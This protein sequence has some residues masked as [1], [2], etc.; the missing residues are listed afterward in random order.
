M[1]ARRSTTLT[2]D[3]FLAAAVSFV[4]E[5]GMASMTM[6]A[7]GEKMGVDAT[8]LYRHFPSKESLID[9]MCEWLMGEVIA[10]SPARLEDPRD[11]VRQVA[12][13]A[14]SV[15]RQHPE[16]LVALM[17]SDMGGG[18]KG[19]EVML[20]ILDGL[21]RMGLGG[22]D[23]VR[24]YQMLEGF[25]LGSCVQDFARSPK[26]FSIRRARY[27]VVEDHAFDEVAV[28]DESVARLADEA[29]AHGLDALLDRCVALA[30]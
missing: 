11:H 7:L 24:C 13:S 2:P 30:G 20:L 4:D 27:R 9:A 17:H 19:R 16:I 26:N 18:M 3:D 23:L 28:S 21:Q 8:A 22:A 1:M 25:T 14:R 15:L 6:R 12:L 10:A 29:F 5:H